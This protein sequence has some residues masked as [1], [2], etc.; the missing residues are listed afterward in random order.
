MTV[1]AL[2]VPVAYLLGSIQAAVVVSRLAGLPDP[3]SSY[4]GN[5]GTTNMW[6]TAGPGWSSLVLVIDVSRAALVGWLARQSVAP[7]LVPWVGVVLVL[8]TIFPVFHGFRGGKGVATLL[9][10]ALATAPWIITVS[11]LV[12]WVLVWFSTRQ[13]FLGSLLMATLLCGG[14]ALRGGGA[15]WLGAAVTLALIIARHRANVLGWLDRSEA[16]P[17]E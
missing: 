4:S 9:G 6:R 5:P 1:L 7:D 16:P 15:G 17:L 12:A 3:R 10:F 11:A 13:P 2:L 14:V 8:G